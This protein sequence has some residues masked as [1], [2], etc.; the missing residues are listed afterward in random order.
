[1][2]VFLYASIMLRWNQVRFSNGRLGSSVFRLSTT[3]VSMSLTGSCFS[4]ESAPRPFQYGIRRR[5][6]TIF[7]AAFS[8]R[9]V[10]GQAFS[11]YPPLQCRCRSRARA[12]LRNRHQGPSSMGFEDEVEQSFGRP[13]LIGR[14][15][16]SVFRLSTTTVSMSLTGSCF[17]SGSGTKALPV[18]NRR[19]GGTI[20]WAAFS[21]RPFGVKRF[22]AIHHYSV[23]VAHGLVLLFGNRHQGP[24]S[25]GFEDEVEQLLGGLL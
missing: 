20:F 17:S 22:Q 15:G 6:G 5:G 9:P 21:N 8:N 24:S 1:M 7:W 25:I 19:R 10:W 13:S 2:A 4:S 23:D 16:S 14:L 12:S 18:R 11:G 3:T